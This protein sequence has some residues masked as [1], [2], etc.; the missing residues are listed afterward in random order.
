MCHFFAIDFETAN[1]KR[2][3]ACSFGYAEVFNDEIVDSKGYLIKPVGGH[4][5]IQSKIHGI[6]KE[7]TFDKPYFNQL[8]DEIHDI[9]DA[10]LIGHSLFDQQVLNA[11]SDHFNWGLEF[12]YIDTF[13]YAQNR[14]PRLKNWKLITLAE[15]L[16]IPVTK[17]H[18][19]M[20][21]AIL[22]AKIFLKLQGSPRGIPVDP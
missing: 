8:W 20:E 2:V 7:H 10:P 3:S 19:A 18:D 9:F 13:S 21:D 11:L 5:P 22:C 4:S 6:T 17:H 15:Y 14:L 16:C 1:P 12:D